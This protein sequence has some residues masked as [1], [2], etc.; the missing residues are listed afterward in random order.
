MLKR[1]VTTH[2]ETVLMSTHN[3]CFGSEI[4]VFYYAI[5]RGLVIFS[6]VTVGLVY[7]MSVTHVGMVSLEFLP[8]GRYLRALFGI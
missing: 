7:F 8:G 6:Q 2:I 4:H 3:I 5:S 1:T